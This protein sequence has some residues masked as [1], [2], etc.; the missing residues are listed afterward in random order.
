MRIWLPSP[1]TVDVGDTTTDEITPSG[2][3]VLHRDDRGHEL[4]RW[5][6]DAGRVDR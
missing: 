4:S 2:N 1:D 3:L 6:P 5:R